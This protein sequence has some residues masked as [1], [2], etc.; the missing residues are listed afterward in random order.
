MVKINLIYG[1]RLFMDG[2][3]FSFFIDHIDNGVTVKCDDSQRPFTGAT[4]TTET[5]I[6]LKDFLQ[7]ALED[8]TNHDK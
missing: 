7:Q 4:L 2:N 6:A 5:I 1:P 8:D 3:Y